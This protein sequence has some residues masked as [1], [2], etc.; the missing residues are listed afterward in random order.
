[1]QVCI[2]VMCMPVC[3]YASVYVCDVYACVC[4]LCVCVCACVCVCV[5]VRAYVCVCVC[6]CVWLGIVSG[7]S[8]TFTT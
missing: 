1:M 5:C 8:Y 4:V 6:V 2:C 7:C 3:V